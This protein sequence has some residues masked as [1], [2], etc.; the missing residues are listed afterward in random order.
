MQPQ[1]PRLGCTKASEPEHKATKRIHTYTAA[2]VGRQLTSPSGLQFINTLI[3]TFSGAE[4]HVNADDATQRCT[5]WGDTPTHK[6]EENVRT[7]NE[8]THT[9]MQGT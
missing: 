9:C 6:A 4:V 3:K 7:R 1:A 8:T 5:D 2:P